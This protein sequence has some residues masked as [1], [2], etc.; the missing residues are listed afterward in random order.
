M[1]DR[2]LMQESLYETLDAGVSI[3]QLADTGISISGCGCKS[4][5]R[6]LM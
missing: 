6:Q 2:Q 3:K 5:Y 4:L 1:Y